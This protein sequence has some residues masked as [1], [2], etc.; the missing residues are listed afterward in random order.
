[1]RGA[2]A[3]QCRAVYVRRDL[4]SGDGNGGLISD[5]PLLDRLVADKL[6]ATA[7]EVR[8]EGWGWVDVWTRWDAT[9]YYRF[10]R[11]R[12]THREMDPQTA[13]TVEALY[14]EHSTLEERVNAISMDVADD[15]ASVEQVEEIEAAQARMDEIDQE[16]ATITQA[17]TGFDPAAMASAGALVAYE[18]GK[19][20]IERGLVR[21]AD[22]ATVAKVTGNPHAVSGGR[23][24]GVGG[25]KAG[26]LSDSLERSLL[27]H[28]NVAAQGATAANPQV[29]KILLACWAV[30]TIRNPGQNQVPVDLRISAG[31]GTRTQHP[32]TDQEGK[33][34]LTAFEKLGREMVAQ[35]PRDDQELWDALS[36][37]PADELDRLIA[38]I[39]ASSLSLAREHK[40]LTASLLGALGFNMADHFTATTANYLGSVPKHMIIEAMAEAGKV[41]GETH[42]KSLALMK[43]DDLAAH[44]QEALADTCWVPGPIR[45][46]EP[47]PA[48]AARKRSE[49]KLSGA[50]KAGATA[51]PKREKKEKR[52]PAAKPNAGAKST[53]KNGLAPDAV[54]PA[55]TGTPVEPLRPG[56]AAEVEEPDR[57]AA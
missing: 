39:V 37:I 10:G 26:G 34:R 15:D 30:H 47:K 31:I 2:M 55:A 45:T 38:F 14:E 36:A 4:F 57:L 22:R 13:A 54:D 20:R 50:A 32:I 1:M 48:R 11:I 33:A 18:W 17:H 40:G 19:L 49:T 12:Q 25:R 7:E 23:E 6:E 41:S 27:G 42:R 5:I 21:T 3:A 16:L 56:A 44:G 52:A 29:A 9:D 53:R 46:P 43:K 8:R 35:L 28:R 24:T 51:K